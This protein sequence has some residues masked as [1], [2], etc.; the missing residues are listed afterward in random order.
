MTVDGPILTAPIVVGPVRLIPLWS[1]RVV[2][3]AIMAGEF[4]KGCIV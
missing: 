4:S 3:E 2:E 1:V